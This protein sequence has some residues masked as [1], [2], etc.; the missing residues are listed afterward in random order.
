MFMANRRVMGDLAWIVV[1]NAD[2]MGICIYVSML[3]QFPAVSLT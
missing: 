1:S 3:M 2:K